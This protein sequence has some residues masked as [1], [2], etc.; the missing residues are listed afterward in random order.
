M[1]FETMARAYSAKQAKAIREMHA[2]ADAGESN[3]KCHEHSAEDRFWR[4]FW[5]QH[6]VHVSPVR[7]L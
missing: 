3:I 1:S 2:K 5:A 7:M 6:S 4:D